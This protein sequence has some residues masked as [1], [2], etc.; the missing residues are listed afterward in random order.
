M[1]TG[2]RSMIKAAVGKAIDFL[3]TSCGKDGCW[4]DFPAML[5]GSDEWVTTYVGAVLARSGDQGRQAARAAWKNFSFRH[6]FE[7]DAG[8][9]YRPG[10]PVDGDSTAW[11]L[12]FA[13]NLGLWDKPR[14]LLARAFLLRHL[15]PE[16]GITSFINEDEVRSWRKLT[17]DDSIQGWLSTHNCVTAAA[18]T[19]PGFNQILTPFL[20]SV[21]L[22]NGGW[23]S[24]WW[25]DDVYATA[26]AAEA[27]RILNT[28]NSREP[29]RQA[30]S[31][32][33]SRLANNAYIATETFPEGSPFV[34]ALSLKTLVY[35]IPDESHQSMIRAVT[36]W[37]LKNQRDD[38]S[39]QASAWL[40]TPPPAM[41]SPVYT[42]RWIKEKGA[43]WGTIT[44]DEA[45]LFTTATVL[46]TF[47][48]LLKH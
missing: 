17:P 45:A 32:V 7:R 3:V 21:Q 34:T 13:F 2:Q 14:T 24:Y 26:F 46:D 6:A 38:G 4:R 44:L 36:E 18:A 1:N 15:T 22:T 37:L 10:S 25:S 20:Q 29:L 28:E 41:V 9:G 39:W 47:L 23:K 35:G 5:N 27:F 19:L 8:W 11:G 16:G 43:A 40:Q 12:K 48:I 42:D 30:V 33:T 31:W